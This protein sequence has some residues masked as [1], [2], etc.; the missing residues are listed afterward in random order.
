[1]ASETEIR[2][3]RLLTRGTK[4]EESKN[5][6]AYL[7]LNADVWVPRHPCFSAFFISVAC[8]GARLKS[9]AG[10]SKVWVCAA[11]VS[12]RSHPISFLR[13]CYLVNRSSGAS[14]SL[15]CTLKRLLAVPTALFSGTLVERKSSRLMIQNFVHDSDPVFRGADRL[16][17][18][19][20]TGRG[21]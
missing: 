8:D 10:C 5:L 4:P 2:S 7:K 21:C 19:C 1:M 11:D 17:W 18:T 20:S 9:R 15:G 13:D 16:R 6:S 14:I 12:S 3:F